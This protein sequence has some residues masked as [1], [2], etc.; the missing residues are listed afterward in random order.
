[1]ITKVK[2][3][4]VSAAL[5]VV[6]VVSSS[7]LTARFCPPDGPRSD[8]AWAFTADSA[9]ALVT[10]AEAIVVAKAVANHPGRVAVSE[11]G[12]DLLPFQIVEFQIEEELKGA[13]PDGRVYVERAGGIE[14]GTDVHHDIDIDGGEFEIGGTY[15][16]FLNEQPGNTGLHYQVNAQARYTILQGRL[17]GVDSE[18]GDP[19][20]QA[21]Q[22]RSP[23]E[24]SALVKRLLD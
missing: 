6:G 16:L 18:A 17:H 24:A 22:R 3:W 21:F 20:Q 19:V 23:A 4:S 5:A 2:F 12:G 8:A 9:K 10:H 7:L 13:F 15:L 1:M 11:N 14:P